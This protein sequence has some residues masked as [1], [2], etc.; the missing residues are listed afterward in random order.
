MMLPGETW[1]DAGGVR[2]RYLDVGTGPPIV[3][4]HGG[5]IGGK[6]PAGSAD[7]WDRTLGP[8]VERGFRCIAPDLLGQGHTGNPSRDQDWSVSGQFTH[9]VDL[10]GH[11]EAGPYHFVG[12]DMG[13]YLACKLSVD[14][15]DIVRSCTIVSSV[16]A[17]PG[18]GYEDMVFVKLSDG[19]DGR[20]DLSRAYNSV[21]FASEHIEGDWLDRKAAIIASDTNRAAAERMYGAGAFYTS[22]QPSL[23]LGRKAMFEHLGH[24]GVLRPVLLVWGANDPIAPATLGHALFDILATRQARTQIAV[25]NA[26]GHYPFRERPAPFNRILGEFL[27]GVA[28][29][30]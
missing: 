27:D 26:A 8:L 25:I 16:A 21:S 18:V 1:S 14:L 7:D 2:T 4:L 12:H 17:A 30:T 10:L 24:T 3:F 5:Q 19:E 23:G 28:H 6:A 13:G 29:G 9:L 15:P 22:F 20:E 11:I